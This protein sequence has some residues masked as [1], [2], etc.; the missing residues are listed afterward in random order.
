MEKLGDRKC[1][2]GA[3]LKKLF[4]VVS[5]FFLSITIQQSFAA[6]VDWECPKNLNNKTKNAAHFFE[7]DSFSW[8]TPGR[9][10]NAC[11]CVRNLE[12]TPSA[13]L[14]VDWKSTAIYGSI[15]AGG[16]LFQ[17]H[18]GKKT[19]SF[20][21][22]KK[23]FWYGGAPS[24]LE[25][26]TLVFDES[27]VEEPTSSYEELV[28]E[29]AYQD[30]PQPSNDKTPL[31][32]VAKIGIPKEFSWIQSEDDYRRHVVGGKLDIV[33]F[34][35]EFESVRFE[36]GFTFVCDYS[37]PDQVNEEYGLVFSDQNLQMAMFGIEGTLWIERGKVKNY[38]SLENLRSMKTNDERDGFRFEAFIQSNDSRPLA[39]LSS[40]L[41]VVARNGLKLASLSVFFPEI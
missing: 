13:D 34:I 32:T 7:Y 27:I 29:F 16:E 38:K 10:Y 9:T 1:R 41:N 40:S 39:T 22:E 21:K 4:V 15:P 26:D 25:V 35:M 36:D 17:L 37:L 11:H 18:E 14:F 31:R 24:L 8:K 2:R 6:S 30:I 3:H 5:I 28:S 23:K 19:H 20:R 12:L 33:D